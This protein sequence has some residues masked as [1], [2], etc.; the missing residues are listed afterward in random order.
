MWKHFLQK[1]CKEMLLGPEAKRPKIWLCIAMAEKWA[2]LQVWWYGYMLHLHKGT[3]AMSA[4]QQ[5]H[6]HM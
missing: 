5:E 3:V 2:T 4:L 1:Y 6:G